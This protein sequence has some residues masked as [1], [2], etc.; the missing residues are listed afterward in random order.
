MRKS[1]AAIVVAALP[2][3]CATSSPVRPDPKEIAPEG[4]L[5]AAIN[6]A[7]DEMTPDPLASP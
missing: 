1:V 6:G 3:A 4:S 5:R 2:C 7:G